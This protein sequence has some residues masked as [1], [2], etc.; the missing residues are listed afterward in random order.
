M[1]VYGK[2]YLQ[3]LK[4]YR[5]KANNFDRESSSRKVPFCFAIAKQNILNSKKFFD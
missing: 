4:I 5:K 1:A 2:I 3:K